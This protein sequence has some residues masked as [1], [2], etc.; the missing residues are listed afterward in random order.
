MPV[1]NGHATN[2]QKW[3][4]G[5]S[6]ADICMIESYGL[7]IPARCPYCG[8]LTESTIC[9]ACGSMTESKPENEFTL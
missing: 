9:P 2:G 8:Q 1:L 6:W 3:H 7:I 4:H 5:A